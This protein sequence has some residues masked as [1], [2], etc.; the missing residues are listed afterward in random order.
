MDVVSPE[1]NS[2]LPDE[3]MDTE[4]IE[5]IPHS[6]S[7]GTAVQSES[8]HDTSVPMETDA[9]ENMSICSYV[10]S[11]EHTQTLTTS[12][13]TDST[14]SSG[15]QPSISISTASSPLLTLKPA[16]YIHLAVKTK[17]YHHDDT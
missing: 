6:R 4:A 5:D 9:S 1:L 11:A 14:I 12:I 7:D 2:L 13:A 10:A 17:L 3:I 8:I 16:F 15:S